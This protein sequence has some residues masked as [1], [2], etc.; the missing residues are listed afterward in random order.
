M[1]FKSASSNPWITSS[2]PQVSSSNLQVTSSNPRV[3]SSNPRLMSSN[4]RVTSLNVW[5]MSTISQVTSSN[6]PI[7]MKTH[8]NSLMNWL[9]SELISVAYLSFSGE[10]C[11]VWVQAVSFSRLFLN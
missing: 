3:T 10:T 5:A 2:N 9:G 11:K 7:E 6:Q 1:K 8:E 4:T